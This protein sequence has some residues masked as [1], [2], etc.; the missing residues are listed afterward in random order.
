[1]NIERGR[2]KPQERGKAFCK[3]A[4]AL[5]IPSLEGGGSQRVFVNLAN[6]LVDLTDHPIHL[7][8]IRGGGAFEDELRSEVRLIN[9]GTGRASRSIPALAR[10][11]RTHRPRVLLTTLYYSNV[12]AIIA[13]RLAGRPCRL[14]VREAN[15]LREPGR[16]MRLLMRWTYPKADCVVVLSPEVRESL[17]QGGVGVPERMVEIGNPGVMPPIDEVSAPPAFLPRPCPRFICA[18][19]SLSH[20]KGFDILLSAFAALPDRRLHLVILGEGP[21]MEELARQADSLEI[22]D[23][24]HMPGF[25]KKPTAVIRH[26]A[27]FVLPSRWEGFPNVLLE[28]LSAG[29]PVVAADCQGAPRSMLEGGQHGHLVPPEDPEALRDGIEAALKAPIGTPAS[30]RARAEDFAADRIARQYLEEAFLV[31][32]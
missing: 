21:L 27:L 12:A 16:L 3:A 7:V 11:L 20:Q 19:G 8:V 23:R 5:F 17:L 14:V 26:A 28:A 10:Y 31:P 32:P 29:V 4:V 22:S 13:W 9:L 1:L 2:G 6:T 18:V 15:V 25:V 30:R 24:V